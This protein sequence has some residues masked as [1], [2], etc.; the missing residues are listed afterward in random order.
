MVFHKEIM[1]D[2]EKGLLDYFFYFS[3]IFKP[4][5]IGCMFH[6]IGLFGVTFICSFYYFIKVKKQW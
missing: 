1:A 3:I 4:L 5:I 6:L 2:L